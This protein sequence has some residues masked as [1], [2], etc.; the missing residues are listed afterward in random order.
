[1]QRAVEPAD[2]DERA[3]L[4]EA[5]GRD[6]SSAQIDALR[7]LTP[8]RP[9]RDGA[10]DAAGDEASTRLTPAQRGDVPSVR[11]DGVRELAVARVMGLDDAALIPARD[12]VLVR[13]VGD[14]RDGRVVRV[15]YALEHL[16]G[17]RGG[18]GRARG[19]WRRR[20]GR[21]APP[22]RRRRL[23]R[24]RRTRP[25]TRL[26]TGLDRQGGS[27]GVITTELNETRQTQSKLLL[28][29]AVSQQLARAHDQPSLLH[30]PKPRP[31]RLVATQR[32]AAPEDDQ[33]SLRARDGDV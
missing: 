30:P 33:P 27:S 24:E 11:V 7:E 17:H 18:R 26:G 29:L 21:S 31:P 19:G 15:V 9:H 10:V 2:G 23:T 12:R 4:A 28:L 22:R 13:V 6:G 1:M 3:A 20:G 32:L 8:V 25:R 16:E 5:D 14:A